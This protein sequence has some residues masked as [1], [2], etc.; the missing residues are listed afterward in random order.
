MAANPHLIPQGPSDKC[1]SGDDLL[2]WLGVQ[3]Q[4]FGDIYR[5]CIYGTNVY[6]ISAPEYVERVF[7]KNW[8][9]YP[10]GLFI[11]RVAMLLGNGLMVSKGE[12]WKRQ[13]RMIQPA[14]NRSALEA[15]SPVI[16]AANARLLEKWERAARAKTSV[17]V[18]RGVSQTI[19]EIVLRII[20]GDDYDRVEPQFR[21]V[22]DDMRRD[23]AF[24]RLLTALGD[25][26]VEIVDQRRREHRIASDL[27]GSLME[28]RDRETG[29]TMSDAQL[30]KEIMTLIVAGHETTASTLNWTWYLLS[31]NPEAEAKLSDELQRLLRYGVPS[32]ADLQ[33]Y[34]YTKKVIEEAMRLYP[35]GWLLTRRAI[36]DDY[37]GEYFVPAGTEIYV[38]PYYIQR[39]PGF[40]EAPDR[41]DPDR[42]DSDISSTTYPRAMLPFSIGPR[43]CIGEH[44]ARM[45]MY[46]HM[47][48]IGSRL[49]L[50]RVDKAPARFSAEV[51]LLSADEFVMMPELK[52]ASR[53]GRRAAPFLSARETRRPPVSGRDARPA[54]SA[55]ACVQRLS[56]R[57]VRRCRVSDQVGCE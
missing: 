47:I 37:L 32:V 4:N 13:R 45:E 36:Q 34:T 29:Q 18:T 5:A 10:K 28:A 53:R 42:F 23:L 11:K 26:I 1:E 40:W 35:P 6:V 12:L 15:L 16:T 21:V 25:T 3:F 8:Q 24:A 39:H 22:S 50:Q 54:C 46:F 9:N 20:F 41:F 31:Q 49:R 48:M 19:L 38:S 57:P 33:H 17:N 44:L 51:N 43:N 27:L 2:T 55:R 30:S 52:V 14:F 7:L 56:A